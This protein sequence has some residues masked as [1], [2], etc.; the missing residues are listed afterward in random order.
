MQFSTNVAQLEPSATLA[1]AARARQL[2]ADGVPIIDL[3]AGEP[4]FP[5]PDFAAR[6]AMEAIAA[7]RT[8]YPPTPGLPK[9]REAISRYLEDTTSH[10]PIDPATVIVGAGVKQAL[11]N[12]SFVLFGPGDEVLIPAPFWP[13]YTAIVGLARATPTIVD[14]T[15]EEGF[16]AD[17]DRLEA[18]RTD[19]TR[20]LFL[21]SPGNPTGAVYDATALTAILEWADRHGIWILSDEIYR[22]LGYVEEVPSVYDVDQV[23]ERV[24]LLDGMSKAFCMPGL[25]IGYAVGPEELIRKASDLQGQTT[26]GAVGPSQEAAVATLGMTEAREAFIADLLEKLRIRRKEGLAGLR[27]IEELEVRPPDGSIYFYAKLVDDSRTSMEAAQELLR[28]HAVA[29]VPGEP[30]GSPGYLRFNFAVERETLA[31]G[32][33]RIGEFFGS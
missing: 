15:W 7:G 12:C 31:E 25:R 2:K 24:V 20:G 14:T 33:R 9:L 11:F 3:S 1:L 16:V 19:R 22:R 13:S 29:C 23:P 4:K 10:G 5:A 18:A 8:G 32:I 30:F 6:A 27:L 28:D 26:S 21:N 17:V